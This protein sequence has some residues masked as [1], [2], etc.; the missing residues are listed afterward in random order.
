MYRKAAALVVAILACLSIDSLHAAA[1]A[2]DGAIRGTVVDSSGGALPGVTV[3]ATSTEGR[4][5]GTTVTDGSGAYEISALPP[6]EARIT[7][8]MDGF[9]PAAAVGWGCAGLSP[10]GSQ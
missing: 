5:L 3:V 4:V 6:A 1:Q 2:G 10:R 8:Q 9:V 7:F